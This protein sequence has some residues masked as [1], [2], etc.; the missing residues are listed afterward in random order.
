M[1]SF[2][3]YLSHSL[4]SFTVRAQI[5]GVPPVGINPESSPIRPQVGVIP[6]VG[7]GSFENPISHRIR[8]SHHDHHLIH[9]FN[10]HQS[11]RHDFHRG[12]DFHQ[13]KNFHHDQLAR[14]NKF[15]HPGKDFFHRTPNNPN[16]NRKHFY[17]IFYRI[18]KISLSS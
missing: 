8:R 5:G 4:F 9:N 10:F 13:T 3:K 6:T 1:G 18:T 2:I 12:H 7:A 16:I 14:R 11:N 17:Y 15:S